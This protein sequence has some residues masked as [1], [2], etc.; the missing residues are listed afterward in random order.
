M[1]D[2]PAIRKRQAPREPD[3]RAIG[4]GFAFYT[5]Q[6]GHGIDRMGQAQ[7]ARGAGL[8]IRQ[9]PHAARRLGHHPR[10]RAKP[11]PGPRNHARPDRRARA[12]HRP[13]ADLDPLR[14]HRD[15]AVRLRHVR[16]AL[17]R[18]R[19]RRGGAGLPHAGRE[20]PADRRASAADRHRPDAH[21]G[22]RG[23]RPRRQRQLRRDRLRR[24]RPPG[25]A[26]EP[27]W[28]R[29][30][31]SPA[32]TSRP[33]PAACSPTAP[34]PSSSRSSPTPAWSRF[35]TTPCRRTAAR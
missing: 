16:L 18:V 10:R 22:R 3:G 9:R 6:S 5:E 26:A 20:D 27:A 30:S 11:R 19:R 2:L 21:R 17:D 35:S 14:R 33:R 32:P 28:S 15:G 23:A 31:T 13:R 34:M 4:V 8:R 12:D 25:A 29:C 7:V 24:Q 1:I